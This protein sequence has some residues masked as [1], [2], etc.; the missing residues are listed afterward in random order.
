MESSEVNKENTMNAETTNAAP[1]SK[2]T[3]LL[4][5]ARQYV[6]KPY[7]FFSQQVDKPMKR[8]WILALVILALSLLTI[9]VSNSAE[10]RI[11]MQEA[12]AAMPDPSMMG[13]KGVVVSNGYGGEV[14]PGPQTAGA[15]GALNALKTAG[16]LLII[17]IGW[18]AW[19][20]SLYVGTLLSGGRGG[21]KNVLRMVMLAWLP[22]A[23]RSVIQTIYILISGQPISNPGLSGLVTNP[24]SIGLTALQALLRYMDVY[25][26]WTLLLLA[27][28]IS[29]YGRLPRKKAFILTGACAL[30]LLLV[31]LLPAFIGQVAG[32]IQNGML[33]M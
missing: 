18:L 3:P 7:E 29:V 27:L 15:N 11:A 33:G 24:T 8:W 30:V 4:A 13:G 5:T 31:L 23:L 32:G 1:T 14:Y 28:G 9:L 26:I 12:A 20:V 19:S 10:A 21:F 17:P 2:M 22:L 6:L 25:F 16:K